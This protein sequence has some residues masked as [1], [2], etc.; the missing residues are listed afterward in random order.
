MARFTNTIVIIG[1]LT[2]LSYVLQPVE[3]YS[4]KTIKQNQSEFN[5][6]SI[7]EHLGQGLIFGLLGEF[8]NITADFLWIQMY[9]YWE[10]KKKDQTSSW[11]RLVTIISPRTRHFWLEG[12]RIVGYDIPYWK[13]NSLGGSFKVPE[14]VQDTYLKKQA[15]IAIKL[16]HQALE[17]HP[18]DYSITMQIAQFYYDKLKDKEKAAE[19]FLLASKSHHSTGLASRIYAKLLVEF[20]REQEA[21]DFLN[22][23]LESLLKDDPYNDK[24]IIIKKIRDLK[25]EIDKK[26]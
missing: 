1:T 6:S 9:T 8:R 4:W 16:L 23:Y 13:I 26:K 18:N 22:I 11:V 19:Y 25:I 14:R 7:H 5:V 3:N 2:L 20:H 17:H 24:Y 10:N 21:H 12:A 15:L